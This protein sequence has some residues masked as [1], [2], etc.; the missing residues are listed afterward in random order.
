GGPVR[1]AAVRRARRA[2]DAGCRPG[3]QPPP[4]LGRRRAVGAIRDRGADPGV[5]GR[6]LAVNLAAS[7]R[8][9]GSRGGEEP[10]MTVLRRA[11]IAAA[12]AI[13]IAPAT[14]LGHH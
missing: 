5:V 8:G 11:A 1:P 14:A 10:Y 6:A 3:P 13:A 12:L 2:C 7:V 9:N 4:W